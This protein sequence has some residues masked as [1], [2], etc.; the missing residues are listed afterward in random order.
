MTITQ[1]ECFVELSSF[2]DLARYACAFREYPKRVYSQEFEGS[3][4]LSSSIALANTLLIFYVPMTKFGR[5][6]SYQV[7]TGKEICDIVESTKNISNYAPIVH[8]ES[9]ISSLPVTNKNNSG[10]I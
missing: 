8:M 2:D 3:K 6:V 1:N 9:K 7:T 4:I 10:L 5:Y